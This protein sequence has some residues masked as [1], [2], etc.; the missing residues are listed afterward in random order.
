[1]LFAGFDADKQSNADRVIQTFR[2]F[3]TTNQDEIMALR[4]IYDQRYKDRPMAIEK[5][6]ALYEKLKA[7]TI[8]KATG[9][10]AVVVPDN[11]LFEGGAGEVV[12]KKLLQ[13]TDLHAILRLPTGIFYKPG[14]KANVIFFDKRPAS[15]KTQTKEVWP[16]QRPFHAEAESHDRPRSGRF[17]L[18][19]SP[20]ESVQSDRNLVAGNPRRSLAQV[21]HS[22]DFGAGQN[23]P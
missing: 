13:T 11:V 2:D 20:G 1:M 9:R 19:L 14:V 5:L 7:N 4:I 3:I 8:L 21:R 22:G 10:A 23:E 18:L 12:R 6:K 17:H 16:Y 15:A